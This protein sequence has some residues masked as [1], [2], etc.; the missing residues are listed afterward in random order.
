LGLP[1]P[2]KRSLYN[3]GWKKMDAVWDFILAHNL[4][5]RVLPAFE[6][7]L[8]RE[9]APH[10]QGAQTAWGKTATPERESR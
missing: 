4:I 8:A 9:T 6:Y 7:A 1:N 5:E 2:L 3:V 10:R